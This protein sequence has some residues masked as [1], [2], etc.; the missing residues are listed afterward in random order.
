MPTLEQK[1]LFVE[2]IK[3]RVAKGKGGVR[4]KKKKKTNNDQNNDSGSEDYDDIDE[5]DPKDYCRGGYHPMRIGEI[6][7]NNR[8]HVVHKLGWGYF[9]TVWLCWDAIESRFVAVKVQKSAIDFQDSALDEIDIFKQLC[10]KYKSGAANPNDV[11]SCPIVALLDSFSFRGINGKHICLVFEVMG[12]NLLSLIREYDYKGIPL[13]RV[14]VIMRHVLQGLDLMHRQCSIIHTDLKPENVIQKQPSSKIV[15][16]MKSYKRPPKSGVPLTERKDLENLT[17]SQLKKLKR[18]LK[19]SEGAPASTEPQEE[20]T[21]QELSNEPQVAKESENQEYDLPAF[22]DKKDDEG[23]K[24]MDFGNSCWIDKQFTDDVQTRQYRAPEVILGAKY[25][26]PIDIWSLA[27][28]AFEL[29]TG[30]FLFDPRES[31]GVPR[32]EDH[33]ALIIELVGEDNFPVKSRCTGNA[34]HHFF[35]KNG[36]LRHIDRLKIFKMEPLLLEK[37]KFEPDDAKQFADFLSGMLIVNPHQRH[38]A[39]KL[40]QHEFLNKASV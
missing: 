22:N 4:V 2:K 40:L 16:I 10:D 25:S 13:D 27:C 24:I 30:D 29:A 31:R 9:S 11:D 39:S 38:T 15:Q 7:N 26:T 34:W 23:V 20:T 6:L 5:E 35:D 1:K 32:D 14:R 37:Y 19:A 12:E 8:Y 3:E 33:L 28:V 36:R 18:K 21:Q 17:K